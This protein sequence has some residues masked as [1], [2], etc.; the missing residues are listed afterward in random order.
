MVIEGAVA[1]LF[2]FCLVFVL[3]ADYSVAN[4]GK[5][6]PTDAKRPCRIMLRNSASDVIAGVLARS[7]AKLPRPRPL[8]QLVRIG[9]NGARNDCLLIEAQV[10]I[11]VKRQSFSIELDRSR[12]T[13]PR[14]VVHVATHSTRRLLR[15]LGNRELHRVIG[16]MRLGRLTSVVSYGPDGRGGRVRSRVGGVF[17]VTVGVPISVGTDGGTGSFV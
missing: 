17:K 1:F 11:G 8:Y 4:G 12:G 9:G 6:G 2:P 7:I 16:R 3:L 15:G 14:G 5:G 13:T 10:I